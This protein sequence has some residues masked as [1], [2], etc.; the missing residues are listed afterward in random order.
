MD[1]SRHRLL[2]F[3]LGE[4][5]NADA[6]EHDVQ[7]V[8]RMLRH[9]ANGKIKLTLVSGLTDLGMP[10]CF[11]GQSDNRLGFS[12]C[13]FCDGYEAVLNLM[14][15]RSLHLLIKSGSLYPPRTG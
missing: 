3:I 10:V 2:D 13:N 9:H 4:D 7:A 8:A 15:Y 5:L 12:V 1:D 14:S 6:K 11:D